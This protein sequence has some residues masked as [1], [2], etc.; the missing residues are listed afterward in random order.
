MADEKKTVTD[1]KKA[2]IHVFREKLRKHDALKE[3]ITEGL[4]S[5]NARVRSLA[6]KMAFKIGDHDLIKKNV[7]PLINSD[8]SKKVLRT[9]SSKITR[10][11]LIKK[12][13]SL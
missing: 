5:T 1:V 6:T 3:T 12:V 2:P 9:L 13:Q 10:K 8:K 7:L 4:K 11:P